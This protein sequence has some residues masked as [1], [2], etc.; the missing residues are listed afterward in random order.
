[1]SSSVYGWIVKRHYP[2]DLNEH[3]IVNKLLKWPSRRKTSTMQTNP[4]FGLDLQHG[5]PLIVELKRKL[6]DFWEVKGG[7]LID[8]TFDLGQRSSPPQIKPT[9]RLLS[10]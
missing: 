4:S 2:L 10:I 5:H 7:C 1:M 3:D 6:A 9:E 8:I